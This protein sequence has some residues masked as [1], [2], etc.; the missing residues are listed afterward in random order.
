MDIAGQDAELPEIRHRSQVLSIIVT[1]V[2][3]GLGAR[4]FYLQVVE[5]DNFYR[6]TAEN[7]IRTVDL[8]ATRGQI[9]DHKGRVLATMV[10]SYDIEV[11]PS[12]LTRES[13]DHLR[14]LLGRTSNASRP[15]KPSRRRSPRARIAHSS[16][17]KT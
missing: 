15:G 17:L 9:R 10:P 11:L 2:F 13:Y 1:L 16:W 14:A 4:L 7:I 3:L 12:Q 6:M 8:P 5:G